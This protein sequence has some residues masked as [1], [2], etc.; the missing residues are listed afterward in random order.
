MC[1]LWAASHIFPCCLSSNDASVQLMHSRGDVMRKMK[2]YSSS[3]RLSADT[4]ANAREKQGDKRTI[5]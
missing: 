2:N 5:P 3:W 4:G 1:S